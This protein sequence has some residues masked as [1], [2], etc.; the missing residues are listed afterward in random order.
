MGKFFEFIGG[1]VD[2]IKKFLSKNVWTTGKTKVMIA[3]LGFFAGIFITVVVLNSNARRDRLSFSV[4]QSIQRP[5]YL[6]EDISSP[7]IGLNKLGNEKKLNVRYDFTYSYTDSNKRNSKAE[8]LIS[9]PSEFKPRI[10]GKNRVSDIQPNKIAPDTTEFII[11]VTPP[12]AINNSGYVELE[13]QFE[14]PNKEFDINIDGYGYDKV[15]FWHGEKY[16]AGT[17]SHHFRIV[18]NTDD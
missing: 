12:T 4:S 11:D 8:I 13:L 16:T 9:V 3:I 5:G 2:S 7:F 17:A 6:Y 18:E 10:L 1:I 15:L 14:N